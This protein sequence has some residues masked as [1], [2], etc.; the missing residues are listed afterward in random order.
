MFADIEPN[1]PANLTHISDC[2]ISLSFGSQ[3]DIV[4]VEAEHAP[5]QSHLRVGSVDPE[6]DSSM[7][8]DT[9]LPS[10]AD[11]VFA[12][13]ARDDSQLENSIRLFDSSQGSLIDMGHGP[14]DGQSHAQASA[15]DTRKNLDHI[16]DTQCLMRQL[17]SRLNSIHRTACDREVH[18]ELLESKIDRLTDENATLRAQLETAMDTID[19][20]RQSVQ[21]V[22]DL[23]M[24]PYLQSSTSKSDRESALGR[25]SRFNQPLSSSSKVPE[26][27]R[28]SNDP[29]SKPPRNK[30]SPRTPQREQ[31][32]TLPEF[33]RPVISL[34][35]NSSNS[36][37]SPERPSSPASMV[38]SE[39]DDKNEPSDDD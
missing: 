17:D 16:R 26:H 13:F 3:N 20:L 22:L 12:E 19:Q 7:N 8:E 18:I 25:L 9:T 6:V 30:E 38:V 27:Q 29:S 23:A 4:C 24:A 34:D 35:I 5:V 15:Q 21:S 14:D 1:F 11:A 32:D 39:E 28:S 37:D 10:T 33:P 31:H 2:K 36:D